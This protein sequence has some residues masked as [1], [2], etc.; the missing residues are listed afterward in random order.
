M[1]AGEGMWFKTSNRSWKVRVSFPF[2]L[3]C[4]YTESG[5]RVPSD[6]SRLEGATE[7]ALVRAS[8]V[9]TPGK[10]EGLG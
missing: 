4:P 5:H 3:S 8:D 6:R 7:K 2:P 9:G 1:S 10:D